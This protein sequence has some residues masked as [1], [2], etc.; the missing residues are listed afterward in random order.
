MTLRCRRRVVPGDGGAYPVQLLAVLGG[1]EDAVTGAPAEFGLAGRE[2]VKQD[3]T[4]AR[5]WRLPR[6]DAG[7]AGESDVSGEEHA[8]A[9]PGE[10][11]QSRRNAAFAD[12][13]ACRRGRVFCWTSRSAKGLEVGLQPPLA[14]VNVQPA[15]AASSRRSWS[16]EFAL[17]NVAIIAGEGY[18]PIHG[19][20]NSGCRRWF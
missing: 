2:S 10:A 17:V 14:A 18:L 16:A 1:D 11:R 6:G 15:S 5:K 8:R 4:G 19:W 12:M 9:L 13:P 7:I 3:A 20:R